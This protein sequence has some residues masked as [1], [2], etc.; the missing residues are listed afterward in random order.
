[1]SES[2]S[3]KLKN[4]VKS[5]NKKAKG[6]S[7]GKGRNLDATH[8][9]KIKYIPK[10]Y[11]ADRIDICPLWGNFFRLNFWKK[12]GE[13]FVTSEIIVHSIFLK[14]EAAMDGLVVKEY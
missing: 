8:L 4:E 9:L 12:N 7:P 13:R 11:D 1:M 14:A 10:D 2:L 5:S 3:D 6:K